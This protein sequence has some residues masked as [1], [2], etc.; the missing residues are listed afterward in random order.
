MQKIIKSAEKKK[1]LNEELEKNISALKENPDE[2]LLQ[3]NRA[4]KKDIEALDGLSNSERETLE[5]QIARN[6]SLHDQLKSRTNDPEIQEKLDRIFENNRHLLNAL[7]PHMKAEEKS[8]VAEKIS[9]NHEELQSLKKEVSESIARSLKEKSTDGLSEELKTL[10]HSAENGKEL[11]QTDERILRNELKRNE[12]LKEELE[13]ST[14]DNKVKEEL[15]KLSLENQEIAKKLSSDLKPK[16]KSDL[17]QRVAENQRKLREMKEDRAEK[18]ETHFKWERILKLI[19]LSAIAYILYSF[20][21]RLMKK[22]VKKAIVVPEPIREDIAAELRELKKRQ[23]SPRQEVIETYNVLHDGLHLLV[24]EK[25]TPPS[26]IVYEEMA[27][28]EPTLDK[29]SFAVTE[30]YANTFYGE[31]DVSPEDLSTFRK[32]VKKIFSYFEISA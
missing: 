28:S 4:L 16:D 7:S 27:H 12:N 15:E 19:L 14:A 31:R 10:A 8:E 24:F 30:I 18:K 2:G 25:E 17:V 23:L 22:G 29:P 6:N 11:S 9:R 32:N 20:I 21:H 26:C 1:E 13:S 5:K 3:V